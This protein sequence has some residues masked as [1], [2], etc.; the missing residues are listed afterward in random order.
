MAFRS[1]RRTVI[2]VSGAVLA[3]A[4]QIGITA[5]AQCDP[6]QCTNPNAYRNLPAALAPRTFSTLK[7]AKAHCRSHSDTITR[8]NAK[9]LAKPR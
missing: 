6:S 4:A 8:I 5:R 9:S 1:S 2:A 3:L 7:A